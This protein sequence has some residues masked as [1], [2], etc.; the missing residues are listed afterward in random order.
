MPSRNEVEIW[1]AIMGGLTLIAAMF[2]AIGSQGVAI[3]LLLI[4]GI[5]L[6]MGLM[7]RSS[8]GQDTQQEIDGAAV[9]PDHQSIKT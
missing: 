5:G 3:C 6:P 4:A 9:V 7:L 2:A 1:A 8:L